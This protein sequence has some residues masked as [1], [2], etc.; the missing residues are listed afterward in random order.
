[1]L[2]ALNFKRF[3]DMPRYIANPGIGVW[4]QTI[5]ISEPFDSSMELAVEQMAK[6]MRTERDRIRLEAALS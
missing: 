5:R 6:F 1:M 2:P 4:A 3:E